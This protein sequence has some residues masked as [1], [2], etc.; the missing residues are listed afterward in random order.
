MRPFQELLH[1]HRSIR[2]FTAQEVPADLI[3]EVLA[4]AI[5]GSSSS[6]NLNTYS[7]VV[8][9]DPARRETLY[10]LH[11]EQEMVRQAPVLLTFCA[12]TRRTRDWLALHGA[13]DNFDNFM[14]FLVAAFDAMILAQT[15]SLALEDRGLGI[16]Y[17]GTT[18]NQADRIIEFL[19]LPP[20]V[21]P[22]TTLVV[23]WPDE[24]PE[25]RDR[26][27]LAAHV[28]RERYQA[29]DEAALRALYAAREARG[30]AR[31]QALG[32]SEAQRWADHGI[33]NLA[34]FYTSAL[35]YSPEGLRWVSR[36]LLG[37]LP[38]QQFMHQPEDAA[39]ATG[40]GTPAG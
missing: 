16:C 21:M 1:R 38:V 7:V 26:L 25:A 35:K 29:H 15:T 3:D 20:G 34:Q 9:R 37:Q 13:R 30:M 5:R 40:S 4:D 6:G 32:P 31:Y 22:V 14:G 23:G 24:A 18:L 2:R 12:D 11:Q 10:D 17:M 19:E 39:D 27:P 33:Q 28:H 8:S 36:M